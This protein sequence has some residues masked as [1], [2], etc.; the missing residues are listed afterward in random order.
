MQVF[1][2]WQLGKAENDD[3]FLGFNLLYQPSELS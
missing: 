1:Q 2:N 3:Y